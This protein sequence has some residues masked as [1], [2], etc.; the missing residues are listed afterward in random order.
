MCIYL[1][2]LNAILIFL[3]EIFIANTKQFLHICYLVILTHYRR[4]GLVECVRDTFNSVCSLNGN[5][6]T[7]SEGQRLDLTHCH[8]LPS[9][10]RHSRFYRVNK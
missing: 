8:V 3:Y 2:Y 6:C 5:S 7:L 9:L 1:C 4:I 10:P